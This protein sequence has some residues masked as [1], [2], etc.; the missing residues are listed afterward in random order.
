MSSVAGTRDLV[1]E[2]VGVER[3]EFLREIWGSRVVHAANVDVPATLG[4]I[5]WGWLNDIVD[6]ADL[7]Y[8]R[9]RLARE[10]RLVSP[11]RFVHYR[12]VFAGDPLSIES[13]IVPARVHEQLA[14][15]AT[16]VLDRLEGLH[17]ATARFGLELQRQL[18]API[19]TNLYATRGPAHAFD[20]HADAGD[21]FVLQLSGEKRWTVYRPGRRPGRGVDPLLDRVLGRN[22]VLYLPAGYWH[23]VAAAE[24]GSLHLTIT[25]TPPTLGV[26]LGWASDQYPE[27]RAA[28]DR[29]VSLDRPCG[30]GLSGA[31]TSLARALG[32]GVVDDYVTMMR[33]LDRVSF[34]VRPDAPRDP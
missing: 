17:A 26:L 23:R 27:V 12:Q 5:G 34:L 8:P 22:E 25:A 24:G 18:I 21:S 32:E 16:L 14:S 33:S 1:G 2:L 3:S 29:R 31:V 9:L 20:L 19:Q 28:L 30:S 13:H 7:T 15:G 6:G 10:G 4:D 11:E